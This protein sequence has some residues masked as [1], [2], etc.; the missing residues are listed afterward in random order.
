MP[1]KTILV[2][3]IALILAACSAAPTAVLPPLA[4]ATAG[5]RLPSSELT[6][7]TPP[8]P[9]QTQTSGDHSTPAPLPTLTPTPMTHIIKEGED[10]FGLAYRY[11]VGLDV[12]MTANPSVNPRAMTVGGVLIIPAG[13]KPTATAVNPSPTPLSVQVGQ[14]FCF[15]GLDAGLTCLVPVSN[16]T[17]EAVENL[18]GRVRLLVQPSGEMIELPAFPVLN[19][20]PSGSSQP[21]VAYLAAP[22]PEEFQ[23]GA[24]LLTAL[25]LAGGDARYLPAGLEGVKVQIAPDGLSAQVGGSVTLEGSAG[26]AK[27]M[28]VAGVAYDA[29][30]RMIGVRRWENSEPL[31][32]GGAMDWTLS[33][34]SLQGAITRVEVFVEARP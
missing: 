23:A 5:G 27:T 10:M 11:G 32:A 24:E 16:D 3:C 22:A 14:P 34:Y 18:S 30:G 9:G 4:S 17:G 31:G 20:L 1:Q 6:P 8:A 12:L 2:I 15:R 19:L 26:E 21:L 33:V 13:N 25:P 7:Y 28:W 29:A